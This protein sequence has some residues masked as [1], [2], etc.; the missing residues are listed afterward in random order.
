MFDLRN[1]ISINVKVNLIRNIF[2]IYFLKLCVSSPH[3][4]KHLK[5]S[6]LSQPS[7]Y[8]YSIEVETRE[9]HSTSS[10]LSSVFS[11]K[12][13]FFNS[14]KCV[15]EMQQICYLLQAKLRYRLYKPKIN[16]LINKLRNP[17]SKLNIPLNNNLPNSG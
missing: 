9:I 10:E 2:L 3:P 13:I 17:L 12:F 5:Y 16:K 15:L 8:I 7:H 6:K 11:S 14:Q 1:K 4:N